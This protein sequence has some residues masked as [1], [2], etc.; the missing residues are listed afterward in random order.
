[1]SASPEE[2]P[3]APPPRRGWSTWS[4]SAKVLMVVVIGFG[5]LFAFS[6]ISGGIGLYWLYLPGSQVASVAAVSANSIGL[7]RVHSDVEDPGVGGVLDVVA[8]A[9]DDAQRLDRSGKLPKELRFLARLQ[10]S[11]SRM[12]IRMLW[13]RDTTINLEPLEDGGT[14][15]AGAI[16]LRRLGGAIRVLEAMISKDSIG[17]YRGLEIFGRPNLEAAFSGSTVLIGTDRQGLSE[18]IDRA[19]DGPPPPPAELERLAG[20][21]GGD[22]SVVLTAGGQRLA[23]LLSRGTADGEAEAFA[24]ATALAVGFDLETADRLT[25]KVLLEASASELGPLEAKANEVVEGLS[26]SLAGTGL[27]LAGRLSPGSGGLG[28]DLTITGVEAWL[29]AKA[30]EALTKRNDRAK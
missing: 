5:L 28:G 10:R 11:D 14:R 30:T 4:A 19:L 17:E 24:E 3:A 9:L 23:A 21:V 6:L 22:A 1:M 29:A 12:Y 15:L 20:A 27:K 18:L 13:P 7:I 25:L 26:A 8:R 16:N 2:T